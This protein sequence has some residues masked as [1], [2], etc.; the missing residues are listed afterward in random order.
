D[1]HG[2]WLGNIQLIQPI[3]MGGQ[4]VTYN[5]IAKYAEELARSMDN[6]TSQ[7]VIYTTDQTYWQVV[8]ISNKKELTDQYVALLE[9]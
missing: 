4:I 9:K 7:N 3:F 8:S 6:L 2:I 5:Q 1:N